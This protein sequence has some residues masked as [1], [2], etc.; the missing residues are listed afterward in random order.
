MAEHRK[1]PEYERRRARLAAALRR[2][3]ASSWW[4]AL[5]PL[6]KVLLVVILVAYVALMTW[7]LA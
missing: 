1:D 7:L 6:A 5:T 2:L 4:D 3:S